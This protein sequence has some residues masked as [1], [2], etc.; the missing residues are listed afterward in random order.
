MTE[1]QALAITPM[2]T[3][4]IESIVELQI[5]TLTTS[6]VTQLGPRFL[7]HFHRIILS[8]SSTVALVA[9]AAG[10]PELLGFVTG[11]TSSHRFRGAVKTRCAL[12]AAFAL[13]RRWTLIR[14]FVA[15]LLE[16]QPGPEPESDAELL[17]LAASQLVEALEEQFLAADVTQYRVAVRS[18]L[19]EAVSFY[20]HHNFEVEAETT[21][22][23][24]PMT[25]LRRRIDRGAAADQAIQPGF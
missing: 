21:V 20:R 15:G 13:M 16:S 14:P 24:A 1:Q 19:V 7:R 23:G 9:R 18:W 22:L 4:D 3:S 11:V 5:E 17:L 12:P 2:A 10:R 8:Q 6:L 25:Y